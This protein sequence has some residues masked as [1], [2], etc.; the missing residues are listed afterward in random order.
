MNAETVT[1]VELDMTCLA[2]QTAPGQVRTHIEFRLTDWGLLG[3]AHDVYLIAGELVANAVE[4]T[5]DHVIRVRFTR[6]PGAVLLGV[7]DSS[8]EMPVSKPVEELS[9][10][11]IKPDPR[12]LDPGHDDGA[13]GWGL[14]IVNELAS[15]WG[16]SRTPQGGKWVWARVR[17][18]YRHRS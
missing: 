5:P 11:D 7:W 15:A 13:G 18:D 12:A 17:V 16:V 2:A 6:E 9:L 10:L 3:I 1:S 14:P 4:A 8:D